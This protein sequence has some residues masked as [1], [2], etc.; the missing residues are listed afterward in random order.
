MATVFRAPAHP[1]TRGLIEC[2][3]RLD[4]NGRLGAIAG[5]MPGLA[6]L[7]AGCRFHPR[8][9][10]AEPR[11]RVETPAL[12]PLATEHARR[13]PSRGGVVTACAAAARGPGPREALPHA[14]ATR[15]PR[16]RRGADRRVVHAV[17]GVSFADRARRDAGPGGGV[18]LR[19]DHD[20]PS[21]AA[22]HRADARAH[23]LRGQD[24]TAL[25]ASRLLP[26]RRK[27]QIVFQDPYSSL[28]PRMTVGRHGGRAHPRAPDREGRRGRGAGAGASRHGGALARVRAALS[29]RALRRAASASGDR[30]RPRRRAAARGGRRGGLGARRLGAR[31]D[32]EPPRGPARAPR[33]GLPVRLPRPRA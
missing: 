23:R 31:P 15:W 13:L 7:P 18:G 11:C 8:C 20:R 14:R 10:I 9:P 24:I 2:L 19:Q 32:P 33:A 5:M 28:N 30:P 25:S 17:D 26:F 12:R 6:A 4:G 27:V 21:R 3:P 16:C 22:R 29:A 1:Y